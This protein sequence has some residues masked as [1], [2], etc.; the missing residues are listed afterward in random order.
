MKTISLCRFAAGGSAA[1]LESEEKAM[2]EEEQFGVE[3]ALKYHP[4]WD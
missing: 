1:M 3:L 2:L 4:R